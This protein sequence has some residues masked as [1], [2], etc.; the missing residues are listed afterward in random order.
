MISNLKIL[1]PA[2]IISLLAAVPFFGLQGQE[3]KKELP[4]PFAIELWFEIATEADS[5]E[6]RIKAQ[7]ILGGKED[8][9]FETILKRRGTSWLQ[10]QVTSELVIAQYKGASPSY[11][12]SEIFNP[13]AVSEDNSQT[14]DGNISPADLDF[15]RQL[16]LRNAAKK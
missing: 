6:P 13:N 10:Y 9:K 5:M 12:S 14:T 3:E 8:A 4:P 11:S 16:L 2:S 15:I 1:V 7:T